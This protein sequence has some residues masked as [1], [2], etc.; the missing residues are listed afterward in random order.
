MEEAPFMTKR[1]K[2]IDAAAEGLNSLL[3]DSLS[4]LPPEERARRHKDAIEYAA[5]SSSPQ[6]LPR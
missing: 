2:R 5:Q 6:Q 4:N 3:E 1:Q